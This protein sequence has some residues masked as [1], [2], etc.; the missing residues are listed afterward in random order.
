MFHL[1]F[2]DW[3]ACNMESVSDLGALGSGGLGV[4]SLRILGKPF[5]GL[6]PAHICTASP[7]FYRVFTLFFVS[8]SP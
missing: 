4:G 7:A 3:S 6:F 2:V 8:V 1:I 5:L